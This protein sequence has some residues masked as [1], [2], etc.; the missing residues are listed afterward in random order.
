MFY[1]VVFTLQTARQHTTTNTNY[2]RQLQTPTTDANYTNLEV[3][4][5]GGAVDREGVRRRRPEAED[6]AAAHQ[7]GAQVE[8]AL[9]HRRHIVLFLAVGGCGC[10][11]LLN[12]G[13]W[14]RG[15]ARLV[16]LFGRGVGVRF[17]QSNKH[18]P[19]A[20][21]R[22]LQQQHPRRCAAHA[23][24]RNRRKRAAAAQPSLLTALARTVSSTALTNASSGNSG[25]DSRA[26]PAAQRAALRSG[27]NSTIRSLAERCA[28]MPSNTDWP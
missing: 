15:A 1:F 26:A 17:V 10:W 16:R 14:W 13:C 18:A 12:V 19:R 22:Q 20:M 27:R 11:W 21:R 25:I 24:P 7:Q 28:F 8:R 9:A 3:R 6:G 5:H 4:P 2:K 23:P